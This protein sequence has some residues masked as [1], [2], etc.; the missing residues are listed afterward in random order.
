[1]RISHLAGAD[2][3]AVGGGGLADGVLAARVGRAGA[4][5]DEGR[6][7][8]LAAVLVVGVPDESLGTL[9]G[10]EDTFVS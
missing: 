7:G 2:V 5:V 6:R 8:D 3:V 10:E 9:A 1:M 4:T